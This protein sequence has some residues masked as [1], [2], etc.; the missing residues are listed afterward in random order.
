MERTFC[1]RLHSRHACSLI[2]VAAADIH[3]SPPAAFCSVMGT[4][5]AE[6]DVRGILGSPQE[7]ASTGRHPVRAMTCT[8]CICRVDY[9]RNAFATANPDPFDAR[10]SRDRRP[11]RRHSGGDPY[12][13]IQEDDPALLDEVG[14][15]CCTC[16]CVR[17][18]SFRVH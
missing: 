6:E 14:E 17:T 15:Q 13:D 12:A 10:P 3:Y 4:V 18:L 5:S 7:P 1:I 8:S 9:L 2:G 16:C 11:S